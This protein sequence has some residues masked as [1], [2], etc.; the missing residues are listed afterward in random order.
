MI[1]RMMGFLLGVALACPA[2]TVTA[3]QMLN[4]S[5]AAELT[6]A[7]AKVMLQRDTTSA[8]LHYCGARFASLKAAS[9]RARSRWRHRNRAIL[10]K[11]QALREHLWQSLKQQ[12]SGLKAETFNLDID[13]LVQQNVHK[14]VNNLANYPPVQQHALCNH[15]ILAVRTG[16]WDV[17]RKQAKAFSILENF[18]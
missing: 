8:L 15:L 12:Q 7:V 14:E 4:D 16:D 11:A 3:G 1:Q 13:R 5:R 9:K 2:N 10:D 17:S 6:T 18:H